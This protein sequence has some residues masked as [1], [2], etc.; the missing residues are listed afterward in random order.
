MLPFLIPL[1]IIQAYADGH[2]GIDLLSA[3]DEKQHPLDS[4]Y[5][6][7]FK[8]TPSAPIV[9]LLAGRKD[10]P[11]TAISAKGLSKLLRH[12][13]S[14]ENLNLEVPENTFFGF[15]GPKRRGQDYHGQTFYRFSRTHSRRSLVAGKKV[16]D[17][18]PRPEGE[19]RACLPDVRLFTIG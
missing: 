16:G 3:K 1:A 5:F 4:G 18:K 15:L 7:H 2:C 9:Y 8:L 11:M 19:N 14:V 17:G 12:R 10:K 13:Q 6:H